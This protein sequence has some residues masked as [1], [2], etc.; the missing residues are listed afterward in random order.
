MW[1]IVLLMITAIGLIIRNYKW[2]N[3]FT[4]NKNKRNYIKMSGCNCEYDEHD[5]NGHRWYDAYNLHE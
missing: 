5:W 3:I 4:K 2:S 1:W